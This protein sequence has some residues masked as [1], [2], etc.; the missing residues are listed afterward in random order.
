MQVP[1]MV[2]SQRTSNS[3]ERAVSSM[4]GRSSEE[5]LSWNGDSESCRGDGAELCECC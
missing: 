4:H 3:S 1:S 2:V 5:V